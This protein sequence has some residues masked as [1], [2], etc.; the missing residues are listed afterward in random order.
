MVSQHDFRATLRVDVRRVHAHQHSEPL[1][2]ALGKM[3]GKRRA[4]AASPSALPSVLVPEEEIDEDVCVVCWDPDVSDENQ[5]V[6]CER[7][8]IGVH[9]VR[10][11]P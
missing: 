6:Y 3:K 5:I 7:C 9:Q 11:H 8:G 2:K 1:K 10:L 4:A